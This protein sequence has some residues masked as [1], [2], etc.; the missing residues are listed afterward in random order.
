MK[1]TLEKL[2]ATAFGI[3]VDE[4]GLDAEIRMHAFN[5][6][7]VLFLNKFDDIFPEKRLKTL[8]FTNQTGG[9][10]IESL[11]TDINE[12]VYDDFFHPFDV[13]RTDDTESFYESVDESVN[14]FSSDQTWFCE[15]KKIHF[16][17][18]D[19]GEIFLVRYLPEFALF[20]ADQS[21]AT[22]IFLPMRALPGFSQFLVSI[23]NAVEQEPNQTGNP[24]LLFDKYFPNL[25]ETLT[26]SKPTTFSL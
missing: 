20:P 5:V 3:S 4:D 18:F 11:G 1:I 19:E 9:V 14:R 26:T 15:Q 10:S 23:Y 22:E 12:N 2:F 7:Y 13:H 24:E 25:A 6:G 8:K 21:E 16:L 17:N